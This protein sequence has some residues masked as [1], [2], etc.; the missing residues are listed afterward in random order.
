M[1]EGRRSS[2]LDGLM[3]EWQFG[4]IHSIS[5]NAAPERALEAVK[6]V[7]PSEMPLVRFLFAVRSLPAI[8]TGRRGLP[9]GKREPLYEQMLASGFVFLGEEPGRELAAGV[10]GQMFKLHGETPAIRDVREFVAFEKPGY[11]KAA[12]NFSVRPAAGRT[13]LRTETRVL[14]T[15]FEAR[16]QFRRYWTL[17]KP[18]SAQIRRSWLRAAK[19]RTE[20]SV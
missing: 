9:T 2:L 4:E 15:S 13:E 5:I 3:S 1:A 14:A 17:I 12:L 16:R 7:T 19:R 10:V 11:A 8:L 20:S 18:G 6:R